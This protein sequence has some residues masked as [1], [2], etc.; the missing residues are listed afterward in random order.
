MSDKVIVKV[1]DKLVEF[2]LATNRNRVLSDDEVAEYNLLIKPEL[3]VNDELQE[4]LSALIQEVVNGAKDIF[5]KNLHEAVL[6]TLG[7]R[8]FSGDQLLV[9]SDKKT[10][11]Q[12]L[13]VKNVEDFVVSSVI[14]PVKIFTDK[15]ILK[16]KSAARQEFMKNYDY[17][18]RSLVRDELDKQMRQIIHKEISELVAT[19]EFEVKKTVFDILKSRT[20]K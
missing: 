1:A 19:Q 4:E 14:N 7:F 5:K 18:V 3:T 17:K 10:L 15:D 16:M 20:K 13:I 6:A 2:S 11:I 12:S 8:H 9:D